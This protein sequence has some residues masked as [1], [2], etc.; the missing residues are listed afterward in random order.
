MRSTASPTERSRLLLVSMYP[1]DRGRWGA[2]AR[3]ASMRDELAKLAELDLVAGYRGS[4]SGGLVRYAFSGKLRGLDGIYVES[5][6]FLPSPLDIAFL[7]LARALGVPVLTYLRDAQPLFAEYYRGS[8]KRW[9]SR[10]LFR[11]TF[12]FLMAFS[13]VVAVPSHGLAEAFGRP[14]ALL[15]PPGAPPPVDVPRS[16]DARQLLF[17]GAMRY[18]VHGLDIL[19]GAI[20][21]VRGDGI[22]VELTCVSRPGEEPPEP[23]PAWMHVRRGSGDEIHALLPEVIASVTPRRRSPYNDLGVPVKVMEYLSYGRPLLVTDCT[24][25]ARIVHDAGAGLVVD[26]STDALADGIRQIFSAP[27]AELDA[28]S[29]AAREAATRESWRSR[30]QRVVELLLA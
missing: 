6:S 27:P 22:P 24:E 12:R 21:R 8:P 16:P 17:V 26:D 20:E 10:L 28:W 15:L 13:N 5:S 1:L 7:G 11:P 9:L 29:E 2:T 4:R 19:V 23:R 18:P 14:D 30:A 3:I 25:T